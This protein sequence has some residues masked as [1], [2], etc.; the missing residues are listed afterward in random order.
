MTLNKGAVRADLMYVLDK[1]ERQPTTYDIFA[2]DGLE[3]GRAISRA[4]ITTSHEAIEKGMKAILLDCGL[5]VEDVRKRGHHLHLLLADIQQ[6][7]PTA[8][9]ELERCFDSTV[10]YLESVTNIKY[11]TNIV[12]YFEEHG[13][14]KVFIENRYESI[15]GHTNAKGMIGRIHREIMLA[16]LT[17]L[18]DG[19]PVDICSR[20]EEEVKQAILAESKLDPAWDAT[21]WINQGPVRPRLEDVDNLKYNKVLYASVRRCARES[22]DAPIRHWAE[23]LRRNSKAVRTRVRRE[24]ERE[25]LALQQLAQLVT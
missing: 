5:T 3:Q 15:E 9:N 4:E 21:E 25:S 19:T 17:L 14:K 22:E 24:L 10:R 16:I 8:F 20:I 18:S 7:N 1:L 23:R 6:R 2:P 12:E 13:N 11:N